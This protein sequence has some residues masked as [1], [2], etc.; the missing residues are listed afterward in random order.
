MYAIRGRWEVNVDRRVGNKMRKAQNCVSA[1]K[2]TETK[3]EEGY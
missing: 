1:S 3:T 2:K